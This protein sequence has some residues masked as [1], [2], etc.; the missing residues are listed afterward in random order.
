MCAC[1]LKREVGSALSEKY[2]EAEV[3]LKQSEV[4]HGSMCIDA[5]EL[6][7]KSSILIAGAMRGKDDPGD[8]WKNRVGFLLDASS[9][10]SLTQCLSASLHEYPVASD[11]ESLKEEAV[12]YR[13]YQDQVGELEEY[14]IQLLDEL[15]GILD[16]YNKERDAVVKAKLEE[17]KN[18]NMEI[19]KLK[20]EWRN[21]LPQEA[22]AR[23]EK[24]EWDASLLASALISVLLAIVTGIFG[25]IINCLIN[26]L[27][28]FDVHISDCL[29]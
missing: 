4:A 17:A 7:A 15:K 29:W 9:L 11:L 6:L 1:V 5:L 23:Q 3:L 24:K 16:Y 18:L 25:R 10:V 28:G 12:K 13:Q 8:E 26:C 14:V 21:R 22:R 2:R 19:S 27:V 20:L